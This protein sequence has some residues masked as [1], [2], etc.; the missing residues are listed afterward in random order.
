MRLLKSFLLKKMALP[1]IVLLWA[2]SYYVEVMGYSVKNHRMIQPIFWVMVL[3]YIVNGI[4]DYRE[5]K[6][7]APDAPKDAAPQEKPDRRQAL[8]LAA[9][10][11]CMAGYVAVLDIIGFLPGTAVFI[12]AVLL[13]MGERRWY[14]LA[15]ISIAF[16][17]VIYLIFKVGLAIPLP[18]GFL[19]F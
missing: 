16:S 4:T 6:R 11:G 13:L 3:L 2:A 19:P 8:R 1:T 12:C 18:K 10:I 15:G 7:K 17:A 9:I 5:W 14:R